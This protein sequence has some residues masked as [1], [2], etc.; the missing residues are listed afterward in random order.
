MPVKLLFVCTGNICRSPLAEGILTELAEREGLAGQVIAD[1]AG[2][3]GY[4]VGDPPD[5]RSIDVAARRGIDISRQRARK[6]RA[7]DLSRFDL[8]VALDR[9]HRDHILAI[10]P[11]ALR[12]RVVLLMDFA[13]GIGP[14][15]VDDPYY[16]D[17]AGFERAYATIERGVRGLLEF[18]RREYRLDP[19]VS[20]RPAAP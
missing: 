3:H 14:P 5:P 4:H 12:G 13:D 8:V 20:V 18:V 16:G 7:S 6:L 9:T 17:D 10:C 15:D 2:T 11:P 19:A 1:S